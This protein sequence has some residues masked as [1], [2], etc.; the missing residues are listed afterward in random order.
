MRGLARI[1]VCY[2]I[3]CNVY[4]VVSMLAVAYVDDDMSVDVYGCCCIYW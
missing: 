3:G 4:G 1:V 2:Y